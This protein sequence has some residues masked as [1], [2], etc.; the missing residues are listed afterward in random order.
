MLSGSYVPNAGTSFFFLSS[1][2]HNSRTESKLVER[3]LQKGQRQWLRPSTTLTGER[4]MQKLHINFRQVSHLV[5][6]Q[7]EHLYFNSRQMGHFLNRAGVIWLLESG[8]DEDLIGA[9]FI[10]KEMMNRFKLFSIS[11]SIEQE[12]SCCRNNLSVSLIKY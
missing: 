12:S 7:V 10:V 6:P 11:T 2:S 3:D 4:N 5:I 8:Q 1:D 9:L